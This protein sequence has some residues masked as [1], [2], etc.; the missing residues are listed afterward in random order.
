MSKKTKELNETN[1]ILNK[2][3]LQLYQE[4]HHFESVKESKGAQKRPKP[5]WVFLL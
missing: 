3:Y 1:L 5:R 4:T 2:P